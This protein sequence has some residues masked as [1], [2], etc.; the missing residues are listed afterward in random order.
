MSNNQSY[1]QFTADELRMLLSH[2]DSFDKEV[3][4]ISSELTGKQHEFKNINQAEL[5][6]AEFY[7]ESFEFCLGLF[8]VLSNS[9]SELQSVASAE[10]KLQALNEV[11]NGLDSKLDSVL[12]SLN[13]D[14]QKLYV[15]YIA[16]LSFLFIN[17]LRSL[18]IYGQYI[19]ELIKIA[20][21]S[22]DIKM[23]DKA[24][25]QA[26]RIDPTVIVVPQV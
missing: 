9:T 19:N 3:A 16:S 10:N 15:A 5:A 18:M 22:S 25:L 2:L 1:N 24:F 8:F 7:E 21:E 13:L 12:D 17:S 4:E 11:T 6:W 26:I 14:D 20:R 23:A